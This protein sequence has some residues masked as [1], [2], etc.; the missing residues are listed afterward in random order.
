MTERSMPLRDGEVQENKLLGNV[1]TCPG[2]L[3]IYD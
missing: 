2:L 3:G 1:S